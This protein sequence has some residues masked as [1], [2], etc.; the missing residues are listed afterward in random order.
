MDDDP[1]WDVL[2]VDAGCGC[3]SY[4]PAGSFA[5]E[6]EA[7]LWVASRPNPGNYVIDYWDDEEE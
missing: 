2:V 5:T 7:L 6:D 3:C 4:V 1:R